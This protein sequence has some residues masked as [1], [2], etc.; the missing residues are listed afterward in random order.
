[1]D[2]AFAQSQI[3]QH[4]ASMPALAGARHD[5]LSALRAESLAAFRARGLPDAR[6]ERWKYSA[7]RA[8]A[9]RPRLPGDREAYGRR[10]PEAVL[11]FPGPA[12]ARLVFVH[13]SYRPELSQLGAPVDGLTVTPLRDLLE[14]DAPELRFFLSRHFRESHEGFARLNT[15]YAADGAVIGVAPGARIEAPLH[16]VF[17]GAP[18]EHELAW[19]ARNLVDVGEGASLSVVEHYLG[20]GAHGQLGNVVNQVS[21]QAGARLAWVRAQEED[22]GALLVARSEFELAATACLDLHALELGGGF[23][24]HELVVRLA[25]D[26]SRVS[27]RGLF[28]LHGRQHADCQVQ[29]T[30]AA[31]DTTSDVLWRGVADGRARAVFQGAI[32]VQAGAD[33]SD[34]RLSNKNLLLSPHAEIDTKPVLEI[35]ADEVKASHGATVGQLDEQALFYLRSRGVPLAAARNMLTYGFCR[36]VLEGIAPDAWREHFAAR[37]AAHLPDGGAT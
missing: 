9:Q 27:A 36:S 29:V 16:L 17:L 8:L 30:H 18:A 13:G 2:S 20:A 11:D 15:A 31:R 25:G 7:L 14:H 32:E 4:G 5:W 37:L 3:E 10:V 6:D 21:L 34:A 1:M 28:A 22:E 35:R 24:H 12:A 26:G 33:G 19:Y 23:S